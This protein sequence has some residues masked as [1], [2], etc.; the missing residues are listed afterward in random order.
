MKVKVDSDLCSGT[1]ICE[2]TCP[3]VFEV[4]EGIS[5]VKV[6]EVPSEAEESCEKAV[7]DCPTGAISVV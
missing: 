3:E 2:Q 4:V 7:Q 1:G 6:D 5:T